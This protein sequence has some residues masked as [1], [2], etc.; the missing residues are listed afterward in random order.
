M[1][2]SRAVLLFF[3]TALGAAEI[4]PCTRP[5]SACRE[6]VPLGA[7][8]RFVNVYRSFPLT[9]P[10]SGIRLAYVMIHGA[11]RN[12][13]HYFATAMA[14]TFLA[15]RT[16]DTLV[17]A[18]RFAGNDGRAC[19]DP[20][21]AGEISWRCGGWTGAEPPLDDGKVYSFDL[22]DKLLETFSNRKLFPALE[23][24]VLAGHSAGGQ[25][26]NRYSA[27]GRGPKSVSIPIQYVVSNPSSYLYLEPVRPAPGM[28]CAAQSGC[29]GAYA[30][31][32]D[33]AKC[34][35]YNRWRYGLD[36]RTGY[37]AAVEEAELRAQIVS[38]DVVYL[39]SELDTLP[40]AGFDSSCGAMA[41]GPTRF[42]R[43]LAY[44]QYLK[45]KH[46]A[47]HQLVPVPLCGHNARCVFTADPALKVVFG[48][49]STSSN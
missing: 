38:R 3:S 39:L 6:A 21:D 17:V 15:G 33:A 28:K 10:N 32:A 14:S 2:R 37:A 18:P 27:A 40:I 4:E 46:S 31:F 49:T 11:G 7:A 44:F 19:K 42:D 29:A 30:E 22:I 16:Q 34:G 48:T 45:D 43:G 23:R 25:F 1:V 24:I 20:L 9:R 41:Q 5:T 12:A 8:G 26:T 13:D 47:R 35:G 36:Q